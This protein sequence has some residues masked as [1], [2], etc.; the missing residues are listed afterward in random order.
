[1][2][3]RVHLSSKVIYWNSREFVYWFISQA[4]TI[5]LD[6]SLKQYMKNFWL[7]YSNS[8]FKFNR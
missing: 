2:A 1:M 8:E 6:L 5:D 4:K 3:L 7:F